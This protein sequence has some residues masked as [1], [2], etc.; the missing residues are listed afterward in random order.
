MDTRILEYFLVVAREENV[1]RA[2]EQL[3]LTQPTLSRQIRQLEAEVGS[4]LF[5]RERHRVRLT[6]QGA[7]FRQRAQEI[8][9]LTRRACE[10]AT[11]PE[12][13]LEGEVVVGCGDAASI[14]RLASAMA[15]FRLEHPFVRF[16]LLSGDNVEVRAQLESCVVDMGLLSEPVG[17]EGLASMQMPSGRQWGVLAR[18]DDELGGRTAVRSADLA[19]RPLVTICDDVMHDALTSWSGRDAVRMTAVAHYN[20]LANAAALVSSGLGVAVCAE[21]DC[22]FEGLAFVPF[23]PPLRTTTVLAWKA[24]RGLSEQSARFIEHVRREGP[25]S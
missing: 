19:G 3:N 16:T 24:H 23:E 22:R 13:G 15:S 8:V 14:G 5:A 11:R 10:E 2:A 20:L 17:T 4:D 12:S 6:P 7:R 25:A 9:G 1:T 21:P 18:C